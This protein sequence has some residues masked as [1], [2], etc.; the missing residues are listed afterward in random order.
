MD[1]SPNRDL[2]EVVS[3]LIIE[4]HEVRSNRDAINNQLDGSTGRLDQLKQAVAEGFR[5]RC[6]ELRPEICLTTD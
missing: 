3:K 1:T 5:S 4:M 6:Q 2:Y